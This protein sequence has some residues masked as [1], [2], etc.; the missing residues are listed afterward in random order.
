[1]AL[2]ALANYSSRY[3]FA[4]SYPPG[5]GG[6]ST[7]F[8]H[9]PGM[10]TAQYRFFPLWWLLLGL[11][12]AL[13]GI[14]LF[15]RRFRG[16]IAAPW[17]GLRTALPLAGTLLF[18][19][20]TMWPWNFLGSNVPKPHETGAA[21]VLHVLLAG[22]GFTLF[23]AGAWRALGFLDRRAARFDEWLMNLDRR[24]LMLL[25]AG[26][27]FVVTNIISWLVFEHLPHIQ[28]SISQLFQAR[29]WA[30]GRLW[31]DSPRFP[32]FFDY[33]HIINNGRWYSQYPFM[34]SL[35]LLPGVLIR[36][37]W[38][39]N[40]LIAA[41]TMP[42][43]YLL[44]REVYDE[45]TGRLAAALG[46]VSPFILNLSAEYMNHTSTLLFGVLFALFFFRTIREGRW[47]QPLL[48]GLCLG[49]MADVRPYTAAAFAVPFAIYALVHAVRE[50]RRL[51]GRF[52]VM[53]LAAALTAGLT[54]IY[55]W[56][57][58]GHP[59][60]FG[61]VV[62]WGPGHEVGFGKS[63]WGPQHTP[64]KGLL[65][66]GNDFNLLNKF[67]FEWPLP[68]LLPLLVLFAAGTRDRRDW[69]LL[70]V[71]LSLPVAYFFY[72]FHNVC[73][74][75]RFLYEANAA[76]LLLTVRGFS[77]LGELLRT[78]FRVP[79]AEDFPRRFAGR[80]LPPALVFMLAVGLPPLFRLYHTYGGVDTSVQRSVRRAGISNAIVFC[81]HLGAGFSANSLDLQGDIVYAKDYGPVIN[82]ALTVAYPDRRCFY[83]NRDTLRPMD[84]L[85]FP[86]S[87]LERVLVEMAGFLRE[88]TSLTDC[89]YVFWPFAD[90][91]PPENFRRG[92]PPF[93]DYREV[94]REIFQ[95]RRRFE[96]YLPAVACWML[97][98]ARE[99]LKVFSE[100][101]D[102]QN[103]ISGDYKF[104]L[105][106]VTS[107]GDAAIYDIRPATG[108][109]VTVPSGSGPLPIR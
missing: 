34:H 57:T 52:A 99:H 101:N 54:F 108:T 68:S 47:H 35:L 48:A 38:V 6:Q 2:A 61:Y 77:R 92:M 59:L 87:R 15:S 40:P 93:A 103:F 63:G 67:L 43:I 70:F 66:M 109:E 7:V 11:P 12:L 25:T 9:L 104:T 55:N 79:A 91:L 65:N 8:I 45:R 13:F 51:L 86:G 72:W 80:M 39:I 75:P 3:I 41:L 23:L 84:H 46:C 16:A 36:A 85:R 95:G 73:F 76:L 98:D 5:P 71:F 53:I 90:L 27:V 44:G 50:P 18:F 10:D 64:Y 74:G 29:I 28:D 82:S 100:M 96:D 20:F 88:S 24:V 31:L 56:L 19:A 60:L 106:H 4:D 32:D 49:L 107:E 102:I 17:R 62:K 58:N 78:T 22:A 21:L 105:L 33:T 37:P 94:S 81:N 26:F 14:G 30:S 1:M 42:L 69:L 97:G 89:R 83:A